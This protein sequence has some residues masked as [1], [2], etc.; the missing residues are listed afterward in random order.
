MRVRNYAINSTPVDRR[1]TSSSP[2]RTS[3]TAPQNKEAPR[4]DVS[5]YDVRT[6]K[7]LWTFHSVPQPGEFGNDTWEDDSAEYT[8]NT[9]VWSMMSV[10]ETL[11]YVYLPFGTPTNDYYGGHR[12]G[13]NLFAESLVCLDA[14]TGKRVWHFQAVHHGLWDYDFPA[15]PVLG[16]I[17]VDGRRINAVAQV[18]KQGF[19]YVFD[20]RTGEPV[21]PIE[22]RP[23]PQS[24]VPGE[25]TSPTQPFPTRP[26]AFDRQGFTDDDVIDFTP[27]LRARALEIIKQYE[28]G[29]LFTPPSRTGH[30]SAARQWRRRELGRRGVRS[31][32]RDVV[33]AV[34]HQPVPRPAA[35]RPIQRAATCSIRRA[36]MRTLPTI[37]G[38]PARQA[39][40]QPHDRLRSEHRHDRVAGAARRR[41]A[42]PPAAEGR[43]NLGPLGGGR[44]YPL[45]TRTLL[46]V[47]HRGGQLG[48]PRY[49]REP[50]SLRALDKRTGRADRQGG[51][52][53]SDR[54]RR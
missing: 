42:Q 22:E 1:A 50:P 7:R 24:T 33:R 25:K 14:T 19:V 3:P 5:G 21:W 51:R 46:F 44:G 6:G 34:D 20:R 45:L 16:D 53:P 39:A 12:R 9:N 41:P 36:A 13:N 31:G 54:R 10:D 47:G 52:C 32:D 27:E 15:A 37:D 29:P 2:A 35:R 17:T 49:E 48:G 28:R 40:L 18:S 38:L 43:S 30:D 11:G 26:P 23:V 8:G 4:G